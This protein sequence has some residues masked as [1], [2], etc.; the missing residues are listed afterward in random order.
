[1]RKYY[2]F[3]ALL[4]A[5]LALGA[6]QPQ[7]IESMHAI[8]ENKE[9]EMH[10]TAYFAAGCFWGVEAIFQELASVIETTVGYMNGRT[11]NPSYRDICYTDTGHAEAVEV[12]YDPSQVDY[13]SLCRY[14]W[15]LHDPTTINQQ[16][17][18]VGSQ[19][20]SGIFYQTE[21][22]REIAESVKIEAQRHW[23]GTIVTEILPAERFY[24]AELYHQDYFKNRGITDSGCHFLRSWE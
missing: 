7:T 24:D 6:A 4:C 20:R 8:T 10:A 2:A 22:E 17:P 18:D 1:M 12:V 23:K 21:E 3:K 14:F 13:E 11:Q 5:N 16:G 15:R 9:N 19:Y